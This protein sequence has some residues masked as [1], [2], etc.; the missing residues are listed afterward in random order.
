MIKED[1]ITMAKCKAFAIRCIKLYKYLMDSKHE[2]IMS[3]Q[4]MRCGTGV[5]ANYVEALY[6]QSEADF[7][8][9]VAIA[10]KEA[11]EA[12]YWLG[13]LYETDYLTVAEYESIF[14]DCDEVISILVSIRKTIYH[15]NHK[16]RTP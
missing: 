10:C 3:K 4:L 5:G 9:K 15:K 12:I 1:N 8:S 13:L 11:A 6:A 2:Y 16:K 7:V 14:A